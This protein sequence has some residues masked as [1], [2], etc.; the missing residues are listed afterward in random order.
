MNRLGAKTAIISLIAILSLSCFSMLFLNLT[1]FYSNNYDIP[2]ATDSTAY[3]FSSNDVGKDFDRYTSFKSNAVNLAKTY[4]TFI[5]KDVIGF[6]A[7]IA[8][9]TSISDARYSDSTLRDKVFTFKLGDNLYVSA[10]EYYTC[11]SYFYDIFDGQ[12]YF[13]SGITGNGD[14]YGGRTYFIDANYGTIKNVSFRS[15]KTYTNDEVIWSG[16]RKIYTAGVLMNNMEG[17]VIENCIVEGSVYLTNDDAQHIIYGKQGSYIYYSPLC[18]YNKGAVNNCIIDISISVKDSSKNSSFYINDIIGSSS[19]NYSTVPPNN[20]LI[21]IYF[22]KANST[23]CAEFKMIGRSEV[24]I[25]ETTG[26]G[27]ITKS[28]YTNYKNY[29]SLP[30]DGSTIETTA[31]ITAYNNMTSDISTAGGIQGT[32]FYKYNEGYGFTYSDYDPVYLRS[33]ISWTKLTFTATNGGSVSQSEEIVPYAEAACGYSSNP[34]NIYYL[35]KQVVASHNDPEFGFVNWTRSGYTTDEDGYYLRTYTA[36]F[37]RMYITAYFSAITYNGVTIN[38]SSQSILIDYNDGQPKLSASFDYESCKII[39]TGTKD[40]ETITITYNI[41][42]DQL[43]K[44][45]YEEAGIFL[46]TDRID[47]NPTLKLKSYIVEFA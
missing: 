3:T 6:Y 45:T 29:Y 19:G 27:A 31:Y 26:V 41:K 17:A 40:S 34:L 30:Y 21:N 42:L 43:E 44:Y 8:G 32:A 4:D 1:N 12:G 22:D 39:Y 7:F 38:P 14:S 37:K 47:V 18:A 9:Y 11:I 46:S 28:G 16:K 33:F 25:G 10:S 36:N 2:K 15:L 24:T 20:C 23:S 35:S 5:I 13:I